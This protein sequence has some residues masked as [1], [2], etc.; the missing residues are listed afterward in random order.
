MSDQD[1]LLGEWGSRSRLSPSE[2]EEVR[3]AVVATLPAALDASWWS[4]LMGQVNAAVVEAVA[5][6]ES[7]RAALRAVW[8][9][10]A[11]GSPSP[12][13]GEGKGPMAFP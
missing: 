7:A 4:G 10:P 5:L 6:P 13:R 8:A 9:M 2:A 1:Q 11:P 12:A 3:L